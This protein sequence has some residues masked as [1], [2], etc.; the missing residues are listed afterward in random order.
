MAK[1]GAGTKHG[2][3]G[4]GNFAGE[5]MASRLFRAAC[6]DVVYGL[7]SRPAAPI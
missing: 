6:A 4:V 5:Q 1:M 7:P 2:G 3:R